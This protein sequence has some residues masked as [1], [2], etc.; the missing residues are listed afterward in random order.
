[1]VLPPRG[2]AWCLEA[3]GENKSTVL[4]M[5]H[6]R[7]RQ[8]KL[9]QVQAMLGLLVTFCITVLL[10]IAAH[11]KLSSGDED[12]LGLEGLFRWQCIDLYHLRRVL[13]GGILCWHG[14]VV[15]GL[16]DHLSNLHQLPIQ[17][18]WPQGI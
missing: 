10:G 13:C 4:R 7:L 15:R 9:G 5:G 6:R 16:C 2:T 1:M 12:H 11:E 14:G 18:R 17:R 3:C 8:Q